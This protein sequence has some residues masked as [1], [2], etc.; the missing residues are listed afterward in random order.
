MHD[1]PP[2]PDDYYR[3]GL[4]DAIDERPS[5]APIL[6]MAEEHEL[7]IA[8]GRGQAIGFQLLYDAEIEL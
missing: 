8:Y 4:Q 3:M 6:A 1:C 2:E 5:L 7:L